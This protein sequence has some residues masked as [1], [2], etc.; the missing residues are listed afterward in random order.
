MEI[1]YIQ[2]ESIPTIQSKSYEDTGGAIISCWI[3]AISIDAAKLI[4]EKSIKENHWK[5]LRLEESF[6]A[7]EESD[8]ANDEALK[9]FQE[10]KI[11]GKVYVYHSWLNEP[12]KNE[13][14][15]IRYEKVIERIK[16]SKMSRSDLI[17]LKRNAENKFASGD[18]GVKDVLIAIN[19][20]KPMDPS[21]LF[22]G[23]CPSA[24]FTKRL[25]IEW[26]KKGICRFDYTESKQQLKKFDAI[27]KGDL[28]ILK[29]REEFSKTM[30]LY[31]HGR[32]SSVAYDENN[33]RYLVMSWSSQNKIIEVP[34]MGC[35]STVDVRLIE[36]V[37][38]NMPDEFY[39]WI[40][41]T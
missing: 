37:E 14:I 21:I 18:T 25:D 10:A 3:K 39:K 8:R 36:T 17:K 16:S 40:A 7:S 26:K 11:T 5:I 31:G 34:L 2:Y 32:V 41:I 29:K 38:D 9:F 15:Q 27:Y 24:D 33:T 12:Q 6:S 19:N 23:F 22:M 28:V 30:K 35:N 20:A 13:N 1:Y 4:A